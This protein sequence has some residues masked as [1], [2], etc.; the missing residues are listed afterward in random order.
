MPSSQVGRQRRAEVPRDFPPCSAFPKVLHCSQH[1]TR[2]LSLWSLSLPYSSLTRHLT[3]PGT[4]SFR[5]TN[6]LCSVLSHPRT[7]AHAVAT[8]WN[9]CSSIS[10][11]L[12]LYSSFSFQLGIF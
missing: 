5:F 11:P 2:L 4:R 3:A 10:H 7:F 1:K 9:I 8:C 6:S 12:G